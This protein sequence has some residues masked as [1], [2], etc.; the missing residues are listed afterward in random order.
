MNEVLDS[1]AYPEIMDL[2]VQFYSDDYNDL[3]NESGFLSYLE[4]KKTMRFTVCEAA[5]SILIADMH[6]EAPNDMK[7]RLMKLIK[8]CNLFDNINEDYSSW[9]ITTRTDVLFPLTKNRMS[10][11]DLDSVF[12]FDTATSIEQQT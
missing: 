4:Y 5:N 9:I 2:Y 11:E 12:E 8:S 6:S 3:S 10:L 7:S 1:N